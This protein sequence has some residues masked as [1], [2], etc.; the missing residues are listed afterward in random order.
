MNVCLICIETVKRNDPVRKT[1][2]IL[3]GLVLAQGDSGPIIS[4]I[5]YLLLHLKAIMSPLC[6]TNLLAPVTSEVAME[7]A[8]ESATC[9]EM[10]A[11]TFQEKAP[12]DFL[13]IWQ[14]CSAMSAN[15]LN[16]FGSIRFKNGRLAAILN[17]CNFDIYVSSAQYLNH[18]Y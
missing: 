17:L 15:D 10:L 5:L 13:L 16:N 2:T 8:L 14:I 4:N 3:A 6:H 11:S 12:S 7:G 9:E 18:E 1:F